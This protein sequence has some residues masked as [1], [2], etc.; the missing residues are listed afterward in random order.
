MILLTAGNV[1]SQSCNFMST[2]T[3]HMWHASKEILKLIANNNI[4]YLQYLVYHFIPFNAEAYFIYVISYIFPEY[5]IITRA[6]EE[7]HIHKK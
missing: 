4:C 2:T 1:A 7:L 3:Q 6:L 5:L